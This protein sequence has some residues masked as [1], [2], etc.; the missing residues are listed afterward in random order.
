MLG[1]MRYSLLV[2]ALLE[3]FRK[4]PVC[5]CYCMACCKL[6]IAP[7]SL[8]P[9]ASSEGHK[10]CAHSHQAAPRISTGT[11]TCQYNPLLWAVAPRKVLGL[12]GPVPA[13]PYALCGPYSSIY[14]GVEPRTPLTHCL[15]AS[16]RPPDHRLP[17]SLI[18]PAVR[19]R[20]SLQLVGTFACERS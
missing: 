13:H 12:A 14:A 16:H 18:E 11:I 19:T 10:T 17:I 20:A 9:D 1:F 6:A 15:R 3:C 5:T 7:G 2:V 4:L 8:L